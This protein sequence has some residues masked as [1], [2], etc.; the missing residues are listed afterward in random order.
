[1]PS[2]LTV[3]VVLAEL[4]RLYRVKAAESSAP[5]GLSTFTTPF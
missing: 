1:M 2:R 4:S 3:G 5:S